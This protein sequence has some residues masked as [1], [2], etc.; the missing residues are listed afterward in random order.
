[1]P[2]VRA[3]A[4]PVVAAGIPHPR[5]HAALQPCRTPVHKHQLF[6]L[7]H[8]PILVF[9][10]EQEQLVLFKFLKTFRTAAIA[11]II[12]VLHPKRP[13]M[14]ALPAGPCSDNGSAVPFPSATS[15]RAPVVF[16]VYSNRYNV[17]QIVRY[18]P[19]VILQVL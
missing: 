9:V 5:A 7:V 2:P 4:W 19:G 12:V 8:Q 6:M 13:T 10:Q 11:I 17:C 15:L 14:A 16:Q 3:A 18:I 1:M